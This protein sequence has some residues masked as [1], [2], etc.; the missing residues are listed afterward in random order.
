MELCIFRGG[1]SEPWK[2]Q[3][4]NTCCICWCRS[5]RVISFLVVTVPCS[6]PGHLLH[7]GIFPAKQGALDRSCE[8]RSGEGWPEEHVGDYYVKLGC[9]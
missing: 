6:S 4:W 3:E 5:R 2:N 1:N 9:S 8:R 7:L